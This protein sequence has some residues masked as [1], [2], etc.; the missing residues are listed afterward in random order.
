MFNE[1]QNSGDL[2]RTDGGG[3]EMVSEGYEVDGVGNY[4]IQTILQAIPSGSSVLEIGAANVRSSGEISNRKNHSHHHIRQ[5][6]GE[7]VGID[8]EADAVREK[9]EFDIL[10]ANAETFDFDRSFDVVVAGEVIEHLDRPGEMLKRVGEHLHL[11]GLF[12]CT[13]PNPWMIYRTRQALFD[14]PSAHQDHVA[15]YCPRTI[16]TLLRRYGFELVEQNYTRPKHIGL[17]WLCSQL[18]FDR[19][20]APGFVTV[21]EFQGDGVR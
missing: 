16:G 8:I 1:T 15:W 9:L 13:T 12:I 10:Q 5:K 18:G 2:L 3:C 20:G 4:R 21:S 6:A 14:D 17:C 7:A 11:G 19:L